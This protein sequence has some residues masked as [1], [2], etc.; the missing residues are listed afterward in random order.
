M[1]VPHHSVF[2]NQL[3]LRCH[4]RAP[5]GVIPGAQLVTAPIVKRLS[6]WDL[7]EHIFGKRIFIAV[8]YPVVVKFM[9]KHHI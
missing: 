6:V 7:P 8:I 2:L 5:N 4:H 1:S 9:A 3:F